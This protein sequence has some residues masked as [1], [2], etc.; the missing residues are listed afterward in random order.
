M[1]LG[2]ARGQQ[3]LGLLAE[4]LVAE[5]LCP[6]RRAN[7]VTHDAERIGAKRYPV[8]N[9]RASA[10]LSM[11][12]AMAALRRWSSMYSITSIRS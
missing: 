5:R 7:G 11:S 4:S 10:S 1:Q 3:S 9:A 8:R 6:G 12:R 2:A